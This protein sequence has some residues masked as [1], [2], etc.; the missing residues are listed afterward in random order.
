MDRDLVL[1][2]LLIITVGLTLHGAAPWP[3]RV[4]PRLSARHWEQ[5]AW[6]ALWCPIVPVVGVISVLIG[7]A[8]MEPA[9]SDE[10]LPFSALIISTLFF[11]LWLR[12]LIR[13]T[14]ALHSRNPVL[15]G[16]VGVWRA[17]VVFSD[18]LIAR[19]DADAMEAATAHEAAHARHRDPLRIWLAQLITDL[20]WP[21]PAAQRR[22]ERWRHVLELARDE[23]ARQEGADGADIA[24]AVLIAAELRLA[25]TTGASLI[26]RSTGI[27]ERI[28]RLLAPLPSD[29][30]GPLRPNGLALIPVS[31]LGVVSG[32]HFGEAFVKT[33]VKCL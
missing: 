18:D 2:G 15:A 12:A 14:R 31:V 1:A 8:I 16:T 27:E 25:T 17:R 26:D 13:A 9:T 29:D 3:P 32:V 30:I 11:G 10:P 19:L 33:I 22:F 21:W 28:N 24:T 7:W 5:A 4:K 20:Q 23:E 6:R